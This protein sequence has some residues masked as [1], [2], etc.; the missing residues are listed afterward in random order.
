[1]MVGFG[2]NGQ[3]FLVFYRTT[4]QLDMVINSQRK[5]GTNEGG[6][7]C[8]FVVPPAANKGTN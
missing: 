2:W 8:E 3:H 1:M 6:L 4:V 5:L 7:L